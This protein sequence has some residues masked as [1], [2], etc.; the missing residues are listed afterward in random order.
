MPIL[1]LLPLLFLVFSHSPSAAPAKPAF[2]LRAE[3]ACSA[4]TKAD[5]EEALGHSVA[6]GKESRTDAG[7]VC[8]YVGAGG[9]VTVL[10]Q[11]AS[12]KLDVPEEI[13]NLKAS[14]PN[15]TMREAPGIGKR[16]VFLDMPD[17]GT[18]LH[19][20]RGDYDYLMISVLGFGDASRVA[21]AVEKI[22]R[23]ALDRL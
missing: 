17:I 1:S 23:K 19:V 5:V 21:P 18:Q 6:N 11:H 13:R 22:A 7:S 12:A 2:A 10:I 16:A 9:E 15:A 3:T 8:S 4:A 20:I 14:F